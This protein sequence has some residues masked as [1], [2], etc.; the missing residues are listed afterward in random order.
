MGGCGGSATPAPASPAVEPVPTAFPTPSVA[1]ATTLLQL[2]AAL[3]PLQ[4]AAVPAAGT[5]RS[6][7]PP[8]F[9]GVPR[10]PFRVALPGDPD[11]V[12]FLVYEFPDADAAVA[13]GRD[14]ADY[15]ASGP[16]R[17]QYPG[18]AT[19]VIRQVGPTLVFYAWSPGG[20]PDR[21]DA[22]AVG[23]AIATLGSEIPVRR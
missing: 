9:A 15:L 17:I 14:L 21:P 19:Y 12:V 23:T 18:D 1:V 6:A 4:L 11:G 10:W 13:G 22:Q 8:S 5:L 2:G 7:E 16:G 3:R 20:S